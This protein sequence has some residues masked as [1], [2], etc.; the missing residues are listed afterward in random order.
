[1]K[2]VTKFYE[3]NKTRVVLSQTLIIELYQ[4]EFLQMLDTK[5]VLKFDRYYILKGGILQKYLV[6]KY[7]FNFL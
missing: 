2:V 7:P 1:M 4:I 5:Y 6:C 3:A